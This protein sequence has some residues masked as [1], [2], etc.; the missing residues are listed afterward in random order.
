VACV[1]L[2]SEVGAQER[3]DDSAHERRQATAEMR[4]GARARARAA[5]EQ[6]RAVDPSAAVTTVAVDERVPGTATLDALVLQA[7]GA[8]AR[9]TGAYGAP[10]ALALR[11]TE[12]RHTQV[13]LGDVP[14]DGADEGGL[15]LSVVPANLLARVE[16][17]RGGAPTWWSGGAI[18]GV[19]R[20][21]PRE[22][23]GEERAGLRVGAGSYGLGTVQGDVTAAPR[24]DAA[25]R[26]S[27]VVGVT[28]S[29]GDYPYV[30]DNGTRFVLEDDVERRRS[31]G[32]TLDA[33]GLAHTS[34]LLAGGR[35]Q[36]VV[37]GLARQG[38]IPGPAARPT[39]FA[40][41]ATAR[42]FG[43]MTWTRERRADDGEPT[44]RVQFAL[45]AQHERVRV[46]DRFR[47][48]GLVPRVT[49]DRS[50]R[51][52]ARVA[53]ETS[54][55][56]AFGLVGV[57]TYR[58][59]R[60]EPEDALAASPAARARGAS[61]R[62][63]VAVALETPLHL[64]PS[65]ALWLRPSV[66]AELVDAA[67]ASIRP[68]AADGGRLATTR[69]VPTFRLGAHLDPLRR[70]HRAG[71]TGATPTGGGTS[72]EGTPSGPLSLRAQV[73]YG[74][75]VPTTTELFGDRGWLVG[76]IDLRPERALSA[77]VGMVLRGRIGAL[78]GSLELQAFASRITDLVRW[79]RTAQF[80]A[81]PA[82]VDLATVLGLEAGGLWRVGEAI[83]LHAAWT[84]LVPRDERRARVL[85]LRPA[86]QAH[87]RL[88]V[89]SPPLG[90]GPGGVR[91]FC[92]AHVE[93]THVGAVWADAAN[94]AR[95]DA[96]TVL[97]LGLAATLERIGPVRVRLSARVDDL[98]DVRGA[99]VLGFPLP[100]RA[101]WLEAGV[102]VGR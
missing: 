5:L 77:D 6:A 61:T 86:M 3:T 94:L 14:L 2:V 28:T 24:G 26:T 32:A 30:D 8:R 60:F 17:Y 55:T 64:A 76:R 47:E 90:G 10:T 62:H 85:P 57:A 79:E 34:A 72:A 19:L 70:A 45:S 25:A 46:T 75:R 80:Q 12:P 66:R 37:L 52:A 20:L 29:D 84:A 89:R 27:A 58:L 42:S 36:T 65:I 88:D 21:L 1:T 92:G 49:D 67:L 38:G 87:A 97:G 98:L 48:I 56:S 16:V 4:F 7:P 96:R 39:R 95:I 40:R 83:A 68:D 35:L 50:T 102:D 82:N 11:G 13:L 53:A 91:A 51:V 22:G 44:G 78:R 100:G 69:L 101:F 81:T 18:G 31:N 41:R 33:F 23:A 43:A 63:L 99:D 54:L 74:A 93:V 71:P 73:S 15:D 59:E 9:R